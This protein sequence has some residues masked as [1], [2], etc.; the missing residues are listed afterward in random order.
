MTQ[1]GNYHRDSDNVHIE[2]DFGALSFNSYVLIVHFLTMLR[3]LC[4]KGGRKIKG[5]KLVD[6]FKETLFPRQNKADEHMNSQNW[7]HA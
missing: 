6:D 1:F 7:Q 2:R 5:P 3:Y 4:R